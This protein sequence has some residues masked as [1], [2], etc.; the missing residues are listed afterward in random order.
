MTHGKRIP[1]DLVEEPTDPLVKEIFDSLI[2]RGRKLGLGGSGIGNIHRTMANSPKVFQA[3]LQLANT[4]RNETTVD[5]LERELA[6]LCALHMH[7]GDYE[8]V[9]HGVLARKLGAS[10]D[11]LTYVTDPDRPGIYSPRQRAILRFAQRFAAMPGNRA[12]YEDDNIREYLDNRQLIELAFTLSSY[13]GGAHLTSVLD[14][15]A[16]KSLGNLPGAATKTAS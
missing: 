11:Q 10:E 2:E 7:G 14:V 6:I 12:Q 3:L 16:E 4:L 13:V 1:I 5:P 15:P 8:I 9:P